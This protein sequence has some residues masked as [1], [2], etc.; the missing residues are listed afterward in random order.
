ME[1]QG[2]LFER[3]MNS[4]KMIKTKVAPIKLDA[5]CWARMIVLRLSF[6]T[7]DPLFSELEARFV[8]HLKYPFTRCEFSL[9]CKPKGKPPKPVSTVRINSE[10]TMWKLS[11]YDDNDYAV[12]NV[13]FFAESP[14]I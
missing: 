11:V 2:E 4:P 10:T 7:D 8:G 12:E 13:M 3:I 14:A 5:R 6:L 1:P 9:L